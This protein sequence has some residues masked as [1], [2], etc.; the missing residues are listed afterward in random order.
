MTGPLSPL[1]ARFVRRW[2]PTD[3]Q[4]QEGAADPTLNPTPSPDATGN[5]L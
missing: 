1:M 3:K 4:S 5:V 2:L